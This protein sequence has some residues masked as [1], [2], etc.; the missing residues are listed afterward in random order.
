MGVLMSSSSCFMI[1]NL[2]GSGLLGSSEGRLAVLGVLRA[3]KAGFGDLGAS[4][5]GEV[6][7]M[8]GGI[9][10]G[11]VGGMMAVELERSSCQLNDSRHDQT[12][13]PAASRLVR[14][15]RSTREERLR[16]VAGLYG[17]REE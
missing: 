5:V 17:R 9:G 13:M 12:A 1:S 8:V 3:G 10:L 11:E 2:P 15:D 16:G 7:L 4:A 6:V 14:R